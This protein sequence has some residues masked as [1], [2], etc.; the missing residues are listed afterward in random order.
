MMMLVDVHFRWSDEWGYCHDCNAPAAFY[1]HD[2]FKLPIC[3]VCAANY[4]VDG[5]TITRIDP[6][7]Y[8]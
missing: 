3:A 5:A 6:H 7:F 1:A 4:A 2:G 8:D